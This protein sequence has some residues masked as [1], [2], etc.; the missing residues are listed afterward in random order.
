MEFLKDEIYF[1]FQYTNVGPQSC[2]WLAATLVT[3]ERARVT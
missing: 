2:L 1:I 3:V